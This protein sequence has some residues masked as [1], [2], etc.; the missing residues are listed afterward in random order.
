MNNKNFG[1]SGDDLDLIKTILSEFPE[2]ESAY[3]FGSRAKGNYQRGSDVDIA[4]KGKNLDRDILLTISHILNEI[5]TMPYQ[6]DLLQHDTINNA[7]LIEHIDRVGKC[8]YISDDAQ[9]VPE[10]EYKYRGKW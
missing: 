8:I 4:L 1:L 5:T 3:L 2:V 10:A 7:D 9:P 6:F